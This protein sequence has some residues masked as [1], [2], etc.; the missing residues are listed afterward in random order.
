MA[1]GGI[2][3]KAHAACKRPFHLGPASR[4]R[5]P[6]DMPGHGL[7]AMFVLIDNYDSFTWNLFQAL[8]GRGHE[9]L[10]VHHDEV[11]VAD[12]VRLKPSHLLISPGPGGPADAGISCEAIKTFAG[13]IPVLGICLGHQCLATVFGGEVVRAPQPVHGKTSLVYHDGS[14][15]FVGVPNPFAA[16]RYHSLVVRSETLPDE[17]AKT[18]QTREALLMGI[19]HRPTGALGVQFHPESILCPDGPTLLENFAAM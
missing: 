12:L 10:V 14:G 2:V 1:M 17:F 9:V 15:L 8:A 11:S 5:C 13:R 4:T 3:D 19:C 7:S 16:M 6:A 18:A